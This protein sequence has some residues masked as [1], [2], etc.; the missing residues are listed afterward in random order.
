MKTIT[1]IVASLLCILSFSFCQTNKISHDLDNDHKLII[2][3]SISAAKA[4]VID[5]Y[6]Q[7]FEKISTLD[8]QI[9]SKKATTR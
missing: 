9:Q 3:D 1:L 8:M 5:D 4:I 2:L 7:F 6:E